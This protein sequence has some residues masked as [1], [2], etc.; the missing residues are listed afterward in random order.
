M[1]TEYLGLVHCLFL[2]ECMDSKMSTGSNSFNV[3]QVKSKDIAWAME[4]VK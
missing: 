2:Y 1:S 3:C 4:Y